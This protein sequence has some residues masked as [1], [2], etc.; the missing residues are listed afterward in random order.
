[1]D[2]LG[3]G[4]YRGAELIEHSDYEVTP[5]EKKSGPPHVPQEYRLGPTE[6]PMKM[7]ES[8][9]AEGMAHFEHSLR[10]P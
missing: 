5:G 8:N 9:G 6:F 10:G 7:V 3:P 4:I 1:S 2:N